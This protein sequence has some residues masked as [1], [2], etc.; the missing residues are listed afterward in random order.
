MNLFPPNKNIISNAYDADAF[1]PALKSEWESLQTCFTKIE[2]LQSYE[3]FGDPSYEAFLKGDM[4]SAI[5]YLEERLAA[6]IPLYEM[7]NRKDADFVR[8]RIV[9]FPISDYLKYEFE[10]YRI[11]EG[12]GEKIFI[13][14]SNDVISL[15]NSVNISDYLLFDNSTAA[16]HNYNA[17]G[18]LLGGWTVKNKI[19]V[20]NY[21]EISDQLLKE[22]V[23][24]NKFNTTS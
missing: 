22:A 7:L 5:H 20:N 17:K 9:D 13:V 23:P 6:Q 2:R 10:A 15:I 4:K 21:K 19:A 8:I 24:F 12:Y 11:A 18:S 3:E 14:K 1:F 16:I